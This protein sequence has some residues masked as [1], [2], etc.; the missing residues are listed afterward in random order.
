[1][2]TLVTIYRM[3]V[4]ANRHRRIANTRPL[5]RIRVDGPLSRIAD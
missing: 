4:Q 1:M 3:I 5:A 2:V